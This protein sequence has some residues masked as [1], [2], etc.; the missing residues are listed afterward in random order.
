MS[1]LLMHSQD[2]GVPQGSILAM[3]LFGVMVNGIA[4]TVKK[5]VS[6]SLFMDD[7]VLYYRCTGMN[8]IERQL[9]LCM[10][11]IHRWSAPNGFKFSKAKT[12]CMH[13]CQLHRMHAE[14]ELT[15]D[16]DSIKVIEETTY[17]GL[18]FD[19]KLSFIPHIM[20]LKRRYLKALDILRV[21]SS[22]QWGAD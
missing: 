20:Y 4:A 1:R 13:F 19:T 5:G 21:L 9:Q 15:L 16:G 18:I 8:I 22:S 14:P 10:N 3:T 6:C 11:G 17:L 12:V 7:L 2:L